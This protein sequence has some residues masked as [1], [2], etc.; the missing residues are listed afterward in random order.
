MITYIVWQ[1]S[2]IGIGS[3]RGTPATACGTECL[4][5]WNDI[6]SKLNHLADGMLALQCCMGG[7]LWSMSELGLFDVPLHKES[8]SLKPT[9][10]GEGQSSLLLQAKGL[11]DRGI[12]RPS[13]TSWYKRDISDVT[14]AGEDEKQLGAHR[15]VLRSTRGDQ[16]GGES[17]QLHRRG[18]RWAGDICL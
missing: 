13:G 9:S 7:Q 16:D 12:Q 11:K 17:D 3:I 8:W 5:H 15:I 1:E 4:I 10:S 2:S 14:L 6:T 18:E